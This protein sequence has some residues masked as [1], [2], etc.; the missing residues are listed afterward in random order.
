[1]TAHEE[2]VVQAKKDEKG[3][4]SN[5]TDSNGTT[6]ALAVVFSALAVGGAIAGALW[7]RKRG[8]PEAYAGMPT[9]LGPQDKF[10]HFDLPPGGPNALISN[11]PYQAQQTTQQVAEASI[12]AA[13]D[14][15]DIYEKAEDLAPTRQPQPQAGHSIGIYEKPEGEAPMRQLQFQPG[16]TGDIYEKA[17]DEV[18]V[19]Q[20]QFQ[21]GHSSARITC[22][23]PQH[24]AGVYTPGAI[25][26]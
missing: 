12:D 15:V 21:P 13:R 4:D 26:I 20:L 6:I 17:E 25:D 5:G 8:S 7:F 10:S 22:E 3:T 2:A 16:R 19:R 24:K 14:G 11:E 9:L 18:P 1:M 23:V